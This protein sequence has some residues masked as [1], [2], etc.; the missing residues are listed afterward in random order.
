MRRTGLHHL[1]DIDRMVIDHALITA[2]EERWHPETNSFN[3]PSSKAIVTLEDI[4][5]IYGLPV[6]GLMVVGRTFPGKLVDP[7][8][9]EVLGLPHKRRL[10]MWA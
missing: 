4:A 10:I 5:Y 8:C 2:L 6:D 7:A 9:E 1:A 3:F